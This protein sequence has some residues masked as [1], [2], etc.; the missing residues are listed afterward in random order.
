M[1]NRLELLEKSLMAQFQPIDYDRF[2]QSWAYCDQKWSLT[3][4]NDFE[5]AWIGW[6]R[7]TLEDSELHLLS[8]I[9]CEVDYDQLAP[10]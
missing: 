9:D 7:G 2:T 3:R 1:T 4:E 10:K 8:L 6:G 5:V